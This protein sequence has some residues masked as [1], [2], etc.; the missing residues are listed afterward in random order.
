MIDHKRKIDEIIL[1]VG[2][3]ID[4]F[5]SHLINQQFCHSITHSNSLKTGEMVTL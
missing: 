3:K 1:I 2:L 4:I 5:L